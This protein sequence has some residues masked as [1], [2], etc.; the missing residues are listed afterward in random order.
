MTQENLSTKWSHAR[1]VG[2]RFAFCFFLLVSLPMAIVN[3]PW[4]G[5]VN[6]VWRDM[7]KGPVLWTGTHVLHLDHPVVYQRT[8]SGDTTHDYIFL[9]L[10]VALSCMFSSVW[11]W[12]DRQRGNYAS[13][14][15][16][17]RVYLRYTLGTVMLVYGVM[18]VFDQQFFPPHGLMLTETFG[19]ATPMRLAW[20]YVGYSIPYTVFAGALECFGGLLLFFR[21]AATLGAV[22]LA[23][24]LTNVV[25]MNIC[26]DIPVKLAS[27][28]YLLMALAILAPS[29]KRLVGVFVG[30]RP[31]EAENI[32]GPLGPGWAR[33]VRMSLKT[34]FLGSLLVS[35]IAWGWN[36]W[37]HRAP[38]PGPLNGLYEIDSL[39]IEGVD[40]P[41]LFTDK[42]RWRWMEIGATYVRVATVDGRVTPWCKATFNPQTAS[43]VIQA[44]RAPRSW[45]IQAPSGVLSAHFVDA[46][47]LRLT[48]ELEGRPVDMVARKT[49]PSEFPLMT[50]QIHWI[51]E[52]PNDH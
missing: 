45:E 19:Q 16:W 41:P 34:M 14:S 42:T 31:I 22:V 6:G 25:M 12:V 13:L 46:S 7:W 8:G 33:W 24:V 1:L 39:Q 4:M 50:H 3:L 29:L 49:D 43:L 26:Y 47:H 40:H 5:W 51:S 20:T 32:E 9:S 23:I 21:R 37:L 28:L 18:K 38:E 17:F 52:L 30:H 27:T 35:Q 44:G 48:G 36:A 10:V 15:G 2:F 11:T